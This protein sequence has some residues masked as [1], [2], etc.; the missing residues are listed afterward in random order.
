[1]VN[2]ASSTSSARQDEVEP[3]VAG[4]ALEKL[5]EVNISSGFP[6]PRRFSNLI[7]D[8]VTCTAGL[9][10]DL[11]FPFDPVKGTQDEQSK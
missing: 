2:A 10:L 7:P 8:T 3:D 4:N 5:F 9:A 1:M 6:F 11:R